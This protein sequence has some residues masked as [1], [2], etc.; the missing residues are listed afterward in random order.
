MT[1]FMVVLAAASL[2]ANCAC[3]FSCSVMKLAR[4]RILKARNLVITVTYRSG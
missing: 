4:I 2:L 3:S 1:H